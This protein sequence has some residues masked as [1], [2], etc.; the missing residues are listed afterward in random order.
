[1]FENIYAIENEDCEPLFKRSHGVFIT[2]ES[3]SFVKR[4]V[5][6]VILP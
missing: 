2:H 1:M 4:S 5:W 3:Y 6:S